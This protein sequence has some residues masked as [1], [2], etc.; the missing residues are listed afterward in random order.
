VNINLT[1]NTVTLSAWTV[2][3]DPTFYATPWTVAPT[4]PTG[5]VPGLRGKSLLKSFEKTPTL[6]DMPNWG[7]DG[8][9][10]K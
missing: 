9:T 1:G 10:Q 4:L 6:A 8:R 5:V 2:T 3:P 7:F